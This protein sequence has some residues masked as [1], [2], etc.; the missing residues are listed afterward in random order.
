MQPDWREQLVTF[1]YRQFLGREPENPESAAWAAALESRLTPA[2]FLETVAASAEAQH[3]RRGAE[4]GDGM[5]DGAF[6]IRTSRAL[7]G[8]GLLPREVATL[9]RRLELVPGRLR[10][11]GELLNDQLRIAQ[12]PE[13]PAAQTCIILGTDRQLSREEWDE[14]RRERLADR[15]AA[16]PAP[17]PEP[18]FIH[19]GSYKVSMIAS[20]YR[21]GRYIERFLQNITSQTLFQSSEL[22]II[23]ADSPEAERE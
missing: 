3:K 15:G 9:Q 23:D 5:S 19:T 18:E 7:F 13:P 17:V 22:I 11:V 4:L 8:R 2:A 10:L 20:L 14:R 12:S 6:L 16:V 1:A 21:G